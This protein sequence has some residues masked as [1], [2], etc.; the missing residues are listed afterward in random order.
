MGRARSSM[1]SRGSIFDLFLLG[2]GVT[3]LLTAA[4]DISG[5]IVFAAAYGG[6]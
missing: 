1:R 5:F 6:P 2:I 3:L 4:A